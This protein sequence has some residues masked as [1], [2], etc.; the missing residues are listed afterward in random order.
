LEARIQAVSKAL[1]RFDL[2][3]KNLSEEQFKDWWQKD[4]MRRIE[5]IRE[6]AKFVLD[7]L[8]SLNANQNS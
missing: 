4:S 7:A 3:S 1:E 2:R 6:R 8:E 5:E